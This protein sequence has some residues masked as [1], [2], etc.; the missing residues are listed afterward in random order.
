M[1]N[2]DKRVSAAIGELRRTAG[3]IVGECS[4]PVGIRPQ[5]PSKETLNDLIRALNLMAIAERV[6]YSPGDDK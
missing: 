1:T 5:A 6:Y 3:V 4:N 2:R